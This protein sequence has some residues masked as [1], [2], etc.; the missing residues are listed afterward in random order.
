MSNL[1]TKFEQFIMH[2]LGR[3]LTQLDRDPDSPTFGCFDRYY[4]HYKMRDFSS[5]I[6]QQSVQVLDALRR[7]VFPVPVPTPQIEDWCRA[8]INDLGRQVNRSGGVDEYYPAEHSYPAGAFALLSV[9]RVLSDW[10]RQAPHLLEGINWTPLRRLSHHM[11]GRRREEQVMN[12]RA[13]TLA[14]LAL[15]SQL[16]PL[17]LGSDV[18]ERLADEL[19]D[20]Q[21]SEGWFDEYGGPDFGYLS[22]T[23]DS[24]ADYHDASGDPRATQAMGRAIEFVSSLVGADD[25]LPFEL[26]SRNTNFFL[27]YGVARAAVSDPRAAWLMETLYRNIDR[28]DHFFWTTDDRYLS[29][30]TL[31]SVMRAA[32]LLDSTTAPEAP[33]AAPELW[34][35]GCGYWVRWAP[36]RSWTAYVATRK[37]GLLR[38]HRRG[39]DPVVEHG[40][41]IEA[42]GGVWTNNFWSNDWRVEKHDAGVSIRGRC[43]KASF[44]VPSPV[45]HAGLR[46]LAYLLRDRLK[47]FLKRILILRTASRQ[48]PAFER[49]V[50]VGDSGLTARD[51]I[52]ASGEMQVRPAPRQNLRYVP[53]AN[54]FSYEEWLPILWGAGVRRGRRCM[55]LEARWRPGSEIPDKD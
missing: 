35:E 37:G 26:G 32:A 39:L 50:E 18:V 54:W 12:Q 38:V 51:K 29:H 3:V 27:P 23:L 36:D 31:S 24:L 17:V 19:F 15:A 47:P 21:H 49:L 55:K 16:E 11:A 40:W 10:Q 7:G 4:W 46:V 8:A 53:S 5:A 52:D 1:K 13:V 2:H 9:C 14:G 22:V 41:R 25:C 33:A 6:L 28:P 34:L 44:P 30:F 43:L 20:A 42:N 48:G 45:K